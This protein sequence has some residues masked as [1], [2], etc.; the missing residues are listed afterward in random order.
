MKTEE[1]KSKGLTQEQIDFVMAENGK[2]LKQ[3]QED[4]KALTAERDD[5]K[6]KVET[7]EEKEGALQQQLKDAQDTI[8]GFDGVD[9]EKLNK[10]IADYKERAEKAE[11]DAKAQILQRDQRDYLNAEFDKLGIESERTRKSL[12]AEIMCEDGLKWKDGTLLG[13]SDFLAKENEKDAIYEHI[14]Y[15]ADNLAVDDEHIQATMVVATL[16]I[17]VKDTGEKTATGKGY[18]VPVMVV[19]DNDGGSTAGYSLPFTISEDGARVQGTVTVEN[20]IPTF[21]TGASVDTMATQASTPVSKSKSVAE[22]SA[23]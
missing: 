7:A 17:E 3:L 18:K 4:N 23:Q 11:K 5:W 1:L 16:D 20:K 19:V 13:L 2:D 22:P 12:A 14:Q 10:D 6:K 8:K 9:V 21:T 15:I